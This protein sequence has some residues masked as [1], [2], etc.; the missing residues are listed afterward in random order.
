MSR[1]TRAVLID[2]DAQVGQRLHVAK[3]EVML[4]TRLANCFGPE[5]G[6]I[7][8]QRAAGIGRGVV[9]GQ[10]LD[11]ALDLVVLLTIAW[12]VATS[13]SNRRRP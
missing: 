1:R 8:L 5:R 12:S 10:R 3:P 7:S 13:S 4:V 11:V 2:G 6:R 9:G